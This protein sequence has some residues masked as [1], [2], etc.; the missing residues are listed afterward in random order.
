MGVP[1]TLRVLIVEDDLVDRMACRRAFAAAG[2]PFELLE[3]DSG[4][5]GLALALERR[6]DCVLLDYHL[7]D[8]TGVE[9]LDR[10]RA[11]LAGG[12]AGPPVMMLTGA[13]SATVAAEA[14]RR[15]ARDYLVK[16]GDGHYLELL[17]AGIDRMLREQRLLDEKRQAEAKFRTLVEQIQAITYI[18]DPGEAGALRY[19]SP[20]IRALG[21][22]DEEWLADPGLHRDRL[23]PD[24]RERAWA[25]I[26]ASRALG[27]PLRQEYR[28]RARI[29][30]ELWMRDQADRVDAGGGEWFMQGILIDISASKLAEQAL[31]H[32]QNELRQLAAHQE[33]IKEE[34]RKRIA[35]E[36]H[37][38][39][40]GLLTGIKA[41]ISVAIERGAQQGGAPDPLLAET[42]GLA[43]TAIDTV[44]RVIADLRPSV[45]DQLG[46]WAALEWYAEQV[47][48]RSGLRCDCR[49]GAAAAALELDPERST[50]LFRVA[51]EALTNV[52]RHAEAS[53]ATVAVEL[54]EGALLLTITDDGKGID[55]EGLLSRESWGI[56]G[57]HERSRSFGGELK[58]SGAPGRGTVLALRLPLANTTWNGD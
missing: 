33:R 24:D 29:G 22:T 10:L 4:E 48:L 23:H 30:S 50:M 40:G 8:L 25:A 58:M 37:D 56:L 12:E 53:A 46:V 32:S 16:D 57:M 42:A 31:R 26:R 11:G 38:E 45:L 21:Y 2:R 5:A 36:V 1:A 54:E 13:D 14:M 27:T 34:E 43:Q 52:V 3:A 35:R 15:G 6:P 49:V 17:P 28:L 51:Q 41:Y 9:F 39:L 7:P 55:S 18:A 19:I 47:A 44:R 20:Q